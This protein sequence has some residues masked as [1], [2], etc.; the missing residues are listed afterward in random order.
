MENK[1]EPEKAGEAR[2]LVIMFV[3]IAFFSFLFY[4]AGSN[5]TKYEMQL[6]VIKHGYAQWDV[7]EKGN[8]SFQWKKI[9]VEKNGK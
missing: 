2:L 1:S 3:S 7:D 8:V 4:L 6:E 9:E 5:S